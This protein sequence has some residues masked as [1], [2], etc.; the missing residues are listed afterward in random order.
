MTPE[1]RSSGVTHAVRDICAG[2]RALFAQSKHRPVAPNRA[3]RAVLLFGSMA[4]VSTAGVVDAPVNALARVL[5]PDVRNVFSSV[6]QFGAAEL[7]VIPLG[8]VLLLLGAVRLFL[9]SSP[10]R[11]SADYAAARVG[12]LFVAISL[13]LLATLFL[14]HMIGRIRPDAHEIARLFDFVPFFMGGGDASMPSGHTTAAFA[15]AVAIGT[16]WPKL[17]PLVWSYAVLVAVSRVAINVHYPSDVVFGALVGI[18]GA[19]VVRGYFADRDIA[20]TRD[21][22]GRILVLPKLFR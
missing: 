9:T 8:A 18:L 22:Q 7:F 1:E 13:P 5:P 3:V 16:L 2:V 19:L 6:T 17:Q 20:L 12:F 14:K 4:I 11:I 15:A 21:S 10:W